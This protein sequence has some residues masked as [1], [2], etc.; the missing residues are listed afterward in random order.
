MILGFGVI[1]LVSTMVVPWAMELSWVVVILWVVILQWV[2]M[3]HLWTRNIYGPG[4]R[5]FN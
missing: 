2:L 4:R 3:E 5:H 1:R